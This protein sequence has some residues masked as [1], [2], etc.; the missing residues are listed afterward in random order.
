MADTSA[1]FGISEPSADRSDPADVPLYIRNVVAAL[2]SIGT[3]YGQ[4]TLAARPVST[5]GSPGK[6]GRFYFATDNGNLYYDAGTSWN[7]IGVTTIADGSITGGPAGAGVKIAA[8]TITHDNIVAGTIRGGGQ[9]IAAASITAADIS[10]ALKP[11][12][13]AGGGTEALRALGTTVST[14]AAGNDARLSDARTPVAHASTHQWGGTDVLPWGT[15]HGRGTLAARPA[16]STAGG[17][18]YT[19]T[20]VDGGTLYRSNSVSW[21]QI[22]PGLSTIPL[23]NASMTALF[24]G[25]NN[26]SLTAITMNSIAWDDIGVGNWVAQA[27][28]VMPASGHYI[29]SGYAGTTGQSGSGGGNID[30]Q[31]LDAGGAF[32]DSIAVDQLPFNGTY[33][34][35]AF[36]VW[37]ANERLALRTQNGATGTAGSVQGR[38]AIA[39]VD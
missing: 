16:A 27:F 12:A 21:D 29:I 33:T 24:S 28:A 7:V 19:A 38:I 9:E 15:I 35:S 34:F 8:A 14:A 5:V 2:E 31:K 3:I 23:R 30:L 36:G 11:S 6:Q 4:G 13:G 10:N 25:K 17:Y 37:N 39:R 26:G 22:A 1:R 20:D 18:L 32:L